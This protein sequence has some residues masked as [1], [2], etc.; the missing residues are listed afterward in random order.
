MHTNR[1]NS[2]TKCKNLN[3]KKNKQNLFFLCVLKFK[4]K[5]EKCNSKPRC[6]DNTRT[7]KKNET[8]F[9]LH[10]VPITHEKL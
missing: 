3:S 10:K 1:E 9:T 8:L 4:K 7:H 2:T 5:H 6:E